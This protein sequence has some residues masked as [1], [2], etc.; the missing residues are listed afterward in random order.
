MPQGSPSGHTVH[1]PDE[2][3]HGGPGTAARTAAGPGGAPGVGGAPGGARAGV[4]YLDHAATTPLR[5]EARAAM[6]PWLGSVPANPSGSHALA[7]AAR[8]AVDDARDAVAACLGCRPGE[9]VLTGG[10]TEADNLAVLGVHGARP[11]RVLCTAVE[12]AAVLGPCGAVGGETVPVDTTG[13]IDL[14]A[15]EACLGDDVSLVAVMASNNEVGTVQPVAAAVEAVRRLA[16]A[17]AV[18]CDAVGAAPWLDLSVVAAG[19]DLVAVSA[20][21][22]GGP[23]G[24]GALVVRDGTAWVP[25]LRGG[26][27]ERGRRPGTVDVAGVVGMAAA[28]VATA[29]ERAGEAARV[30]ALRD[31]MVAALCAADDGIRP[32]LGDALA[33]RALPG[34]AHLLVAGVDAEEL[35][36]SLD[37]HGVCASAGSACASGALEPSHVLLAMGCDPARA[38]GAVRF[39]LG[40]TTTEADVDR[41]VALLPALVADLRSS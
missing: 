36:L 10:G 13:T 14:A 17:A 4:T 21:K 33:T 35:L 39:T 15:L 25:P 18:H 31:R 2:Q 34:H 6:E 40:R 16:P 26:S 11:G 38:R 22:F 32:T 23:H 20:H 9:V 1:V 29:A 30:G 24:A 5:P 12:H 19:C 41:V 7:R 28:L 8:R 37:R 27:Q 3:R